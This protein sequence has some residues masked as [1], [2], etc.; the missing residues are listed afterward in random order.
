MEFAPEKI[1]DFN[2]LLEHWKEYVFFTINPDMA[3]ASL[4]IRSGMHPRIELEPIDMLTYKK[5]ILF[6]FSREYGFIEDMSFSDMEIENNRF[7]GGVHK[8]RKITKVLTELIKQELPYRTE[9]RLDFFSKLRKPNNK[10]YIDSDPIKLMEAYTKIGTCVSPE[11]DNQSNMLKFLV[12]PHTYI[13]YDEDFSARMMI[14]ANFDKKTVFL[15]NVYGNYDYMFALT[16]VKYFVDNGFAF[17]G[18]LSDGFSAGYMSYTD[19]HSSRFMNHVEFFGGL[20]GIP[21]PEKREERTNLWTQPSWYHSHIDA[22]SGGHLYDHTYTALFDFHDGSGYILEEGY[23]HCRE[24]GEIVSG[25]DY[26]FDTEMCN[27]C[28][29][30][31]NWC[32]ECQE[33]HSADDYNFEAN[34]CNDCFANTHSHCEVCGEDVLDLQYDQDRRMCDKCAET[35]DRCTECSEV[36]LIEDFNDDLEM[37]RA[38][39]A[40]VEENEDAED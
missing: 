34:M 24:C 6:D 18:D 7:L 39:A 27:S 16:I 40:E 4:E 17:S 21:Y 33:Y 20:R 8:D 38:C 3:E 5:A 28:S 23:E 9:Q 12:S 14:Y 2:N 22:I 31:R 32:D 10:Y 15:H 29:D 30:Y 13:A 11:G 19:S 25:D 1:A 26:D 36:V 35:H 37:C